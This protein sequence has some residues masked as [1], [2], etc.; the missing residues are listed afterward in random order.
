MIADIA[1]FE[2]EVSWELTVLG[3]TAPLMPLT[4]TGATLDVR[5]NEITIGLGSVVSGTELLEAF[6]TRLLPLAFGAAWKVLDL[7]MELSLAVGGQ[8]PTGRTWRIAEKSALV[9]SH[10]PKIPSTKLSIPVST[11]IARLYTAT[12]EA[13][14]ALV[15]RRV[16]VDAATRALQAFD[17]NGAPL[18][19][20]SLT[21]QQAF[22][23]LSQRLAH[24]IITGTKSARAELELRGHL[25]ELVAHHGQVNLGT[26]AQRPPVR[27][28]A[29]LEGGA[30]DVPALMERA[31]R[32]FP[33]AVYVDLEL[34]LEDGRVARAELESA[35]QT[36]VPVDPRSLPS[37][38]TV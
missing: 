3:E 28:V 24:A 6:K 1:D 13:R 12:L 22:C 38:L 15:H 26:G 29:S 7:A 34:H 33:G 18:K 20:I 14:H 25:Q 19:A 10:P 4:A 35:P 2:E 27:V 32:V 16:Q 17:P 31:T 37:W 5:K 30:I 36:K 21:E 11:A 23:R 9:A 8:R